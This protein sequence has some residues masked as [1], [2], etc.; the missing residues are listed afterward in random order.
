MKVANNPSVETSIDVLK[1]LISLFKECLETRFS[2]RQLARFEEGLSKLSAC[3]VFSLENDNEKISFWINV[4]NAIYLYFLAK[5]KTKSQAKQNPLAFYLFSNYNKIQVGHSLFTLNE[6]KDG[7]LRQNRIAKK[8]AKPCLKQKDP[9]LTLLPEKFDYRIH[10]ALYST[11]D[12]HYEHTYF[13]DINLDFEL[14][15]CERVY[16]TRNFIYDLEF[17]RVAHVPVYTKYLFDFEEK[18]LSDP[19]FVNFKRVKIIID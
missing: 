11:P 1:H 17:A 10:F 3:E 9:R 19:Q 12:Y 6:I 13:T 18:Y 15:E 4:Y 7:I 2:S 14:G 16:S 8:R 5:T